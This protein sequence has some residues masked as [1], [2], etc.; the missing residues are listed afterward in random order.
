MLRLLLFFSMLSFL[1]GD[2]FE[3]APV[4]YSKTEADTPL[5][6]LFQKIES[7]ETS[8]RGE[9][10][11]EILMQVLA[12]LE[13]PV[14][15]QVLVFSKTSA[16]NSRISPWT[17][18]AI[19]FSD[20][21]YVGWV[22]GGN[23]ETV[24]FDKNL[25]A[26]FHI[27]DLNRRQKGELPELRR[28]RG[29]L[30][31]HASSVTHGAPGL[32]VRSVY[33]DESGRPLF[34]RGSFNTTHHSPIRERWGGWYVTGQ[35]GPAGHLGNFTFNENNT[36]SS[37]TRSRPVTDLTPFFNAKPYPGGGS[38]DAVA[39]MILEHQ[40]TVHN[41]LLS[42]HLATRRFLH[43]NEAIRKATGEPTD[44]PLSE[45]YRHALDHYGDKVVKAL[46]FEGEF[47]L[48]DEGVEGSEAFQKAFASKALRNKRRRSLR[49]LR[50][51]ERLFKYR[52]SYLIYGDVF[53][54]LHPL[55]RKDILQKLKGI[56]TNPEDHPDYGYL[57]NSERKHILDILSETF[58]GWDDISL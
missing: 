8:F 35:A 39:L 37:L 2:T 50:L 15:S 52:C 33:P 51:Y 9:S 43:Q 47:E 23:I 14:E 5:T 4:L 19:Y 17:P 11:K 31:C 27:I 6:R 48:V 49:D 46:L 41:V 13:I 44:S 54:D 3:E 40:I 7:G 10:D 55:L 53:R 20:N 1:S 12:A 24:T 28:D 26:I 57:S 25:G 38:S 36:R 18:R 34:D 58:P 29:C 22:Q 21:A 16:Q 42:G 45:T 30:S 56:L 32:L